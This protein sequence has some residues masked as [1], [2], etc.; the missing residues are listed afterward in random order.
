MWLT[1][2]K[3]WYNVTH[4][5]INTIILNQISTHVKFEQIYV[6]S[7]EHTTK[8]ATDLLQVVNFT[9]L[10]ELVNKLQQ[11]YQLYQV[12]KNLS[13]RDCNL[14]FSD[15][16]QLVETTCSKPV[17]NKFCQSTCDRHVVNKLSQAIRTD[18]HISL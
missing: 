2:H 5:F 7:Y 18:P 16:L 12:V 9:C 1:Q 4:L 6:F 11:T 13:N 17:G 8:N 15:L 14:S 10:F 3:C